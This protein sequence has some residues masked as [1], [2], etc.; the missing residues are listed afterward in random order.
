MSHAAVSLLPSSALV[1]TID[2]TAE[3][4]AARHR[5]RARRC[6]ITQPSRI[7]RSTRGVVSPRCFGTSSG[8]FAKISSAREP[9]QRIDVRAELQSFGLRLLQ[10]C[11]RTERAGALLDGL[12]E[13]PLRQRRGEQQRDQR[14]AGGD[15]EQR[16]ALRIAAKAGDVALDP[17]KRSEH[18]ERAVVAGAAVLRL[19]RQRRMRQKAEHADAVVDGDQHDA[20][21]GKTLAV[22][23]RVRRTAGD[24]AAAV[25]PDHHRQLLARRAAPASR[26]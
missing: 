23:A 16:H 25:E 18:V 26:C 13:Q 1:P 6:L 15:A 5:R 17:G 9:A 22:A 19:R 10:A 24:K 11:K 8:V 4:L 20:L 3:D 21:A 14:G 7:G 12:L 2:G